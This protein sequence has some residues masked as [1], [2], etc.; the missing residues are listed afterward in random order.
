MI[1]TEAMWSLAFGSKKKHN[2]SNEMAGFETGDNKISLCNIAWWG[3]QSS[4]G[5][6]TNHNR[7]MW[8]DW[9][10]ELSK[11]KIRQMKWWDFKP[12]TTI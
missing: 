1:F 5:I 12:E 3:W 10:L 2:P 8:G 9:D 6:K 11:N 7:R 4:L